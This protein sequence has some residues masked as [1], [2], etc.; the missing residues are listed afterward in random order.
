MTP[1]DFDAMATLKNRLNALTPSEVKSRA[2]AFAREFQRTAEEITGQ[3][4]PLP[5]PEQSGGVVASTNWDYKNPMAQLKAMLYGIAPEDDEMVF[6]GFSYNPDIVSVIGP[7]ARRVVILH[8]IA[9]LMAGYQ[10]GVKGGHTPEWR[11]V[12]KEIGL[13]RPV[14]EP[15]PATFVALDK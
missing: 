7:K 12:C 9:H 14:A 6:T 13:S 5:E 15:H 10:G 11:N 3:K 8:E 1:A 4:I 2:D